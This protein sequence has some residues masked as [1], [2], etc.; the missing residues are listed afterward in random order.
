M[1]CQF[2]GVLGPVKME[3]FLQLVTLVGVPKRNIRW[4]GGSSG[5]AD[6]AAA[7]VQFAKTI[8]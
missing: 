8:H 7:N 6:F 1:V 4:D 5:V 2:V 3:S